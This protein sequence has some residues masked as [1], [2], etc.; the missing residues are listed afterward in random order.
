PKVKQFRFE[1]F[2]TSREPGVCMNWPLEAN[3]EALDLRLAAAPSFPADLSAKDQKNVVVDT[4]SDERG[5]AYAETQIDSYDFGGHTTLRVVCVLQDGREL[6]GLLKSQGDELAMIPVP[7][8]RSGSKI[9]KSWADRVGLNGSDGE[10]LDATPVGD[11]NQGDGF[12]NYEEYRGFVQLDEHLRTRPD[13]KDLFIRNLLGRR[14]LPGIF[15]YADLTQVTVHYELQPAE[16]PASRRMNSNRSADSPR[17]CAEDQY[18]HGLI[19]DKIVGG[20]A[21]ITD[22]EGDLWRP[23]YVSSV[24]ILWELFDSGNEEQLASTIAHE[25]MHA[26]GVRHHGDWDDYVVWL[27]KSREINGRVEH[28]FEER[29]ASFDEGR[30]QFIFP[31]TPGARIRIF[32]DS[33]NEVPAEVGVL[34]PQPQIM[35]LGHYGQQH[36]GDVNCVMR[37]HCAQAFVIPSRPRDRFL[38]PGEPFATGI[39]SS[40]VGTG[41]N[42]P[43]PPG[44]AFARYSA[45]SRGDCVHRICVRDDAAEKTITP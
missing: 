32:K 3:D 2:E 22:M 5:L 15:R 19:L 11:D 7:W 16:M 6:L 44:Q 37:Y 27:Q 31:A 12:S 34:L 10:D 30:G 1:L 23:Q 21:S 4:L 26:T 24:Q 25:L 8:R 41:F 20:D 28:W 33:V 36:S 43:Q 38:S 40:A 17:T 13:R 35:F 39:C 18:Q 45:A 14:A 9:A 29:P 42:A